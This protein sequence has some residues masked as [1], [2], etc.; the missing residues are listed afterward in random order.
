MP[1]DYLSYDGQLVDDAPLIVAVYASTWRKYLL[2]LAEYLRQREVWDPVD[3]IDLAIQQSDALISILLGVDS[4]PIPSFPIHHTLLF[5]EALVNVGVK[6][7]AIFFNVNQMLGTFWYQNIA[8]NGD[9]WNWSL[10]LAQGDYH[11]TIVGV[12]AADNGK[13]EVYIDGVLVASSLFD[14]YAAATA[15]N[16][17]QTLEISLAASDFHGIQVKV[18][19]KNAAS[20]GYYVRATTMILRYR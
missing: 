13:T 10:N 4:V 9:I 18:N 3:D 1:S 19:G 12:R 7:P 14:W 17:T 5:G 8:A 11:L 20:G 2:A 6:T 16:I 15:W